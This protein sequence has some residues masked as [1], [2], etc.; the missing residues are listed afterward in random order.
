MQPGFGAE[1]R[2][3]SAEARALRA[4]ARDSMDMEQ[5]FKWAEA[6]VGFQAMVWFASQGSR[7][8]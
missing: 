1:L 2:D 3:A 5:L 4:V 6:Q 7:N 8:S